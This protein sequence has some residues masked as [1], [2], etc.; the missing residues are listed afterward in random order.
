MTDDRST[1]T[2]QDPVDALIDATHASL[3]RAR[4]AV[5]PDFAAVLAH[6]A[7]LTSGDATPDFMHAVADAEREAAD[8]GQVDEPVIDIRTRARAGAGA[9]DGIAGLVSDARASVGRM[10]DTARM[11][12]IPPMPRHVPRLAVSAIGA[13]GLAA[14]AVVAFAVMQWSSSADRAQH[15]APL[16]Q[17]V[18]IDATDEAAR[19]ATYEIGVPGATRPAPPATAPQP[20]PAATPAMPQPSP[21]VGSA[22]RPRVAAPHSD[23]DLLRGLSDE[24]RALWRAGDRVAAEAK[25][26][27]VTAA[28]GRS[29][30]AE[31]AWGDLFAL[32]NQ[33]GD[34]A[35]RTKRW[36]AYVAKF[37][38][39]RY[40]DDARAGLCR[41]SSTPSEC[42]AKYLLDFPKGSYGTEA[43]AAAPKGE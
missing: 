34:D 5:P 38:R 22:P 23:A 24:A 9:V 31:L 19:Q 33:L 30:L 1:R 28:G 40:A 42:W 8:G 35:R 3:S 20:S 39:G 43:R 16:D 7:V 26:L 13:V 36:R 18:R 32:A 25:F 4:A 41:A 11:R 6:A 29:A 27:Q 12:A 15:S 14:A 21:A 2:G 10:I 17:A 37:P